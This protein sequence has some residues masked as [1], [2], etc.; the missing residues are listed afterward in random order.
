MSSWPPGLILIIG[1]LLLPVLRGRARQAVALALPLLSAW[2]L[3]MLPA[4]ARVEATIF[5]YELLVVRADKMA[6]VWGVIF[7]IAAFVSILYAIHVK[8]VGQHVAGLVYAGSAIGAVYAGDL[9]TLFVYWELTAI[10]SVFLVWASRT[11]RSYRSGMRYLVIQVGSGVILLS[12]ILMRV[13]AGQDLAFA[14]LGLQDVATGL[15]FVA[16]GI[17]AAFPLLHTWLKDAYPEATPTGTVF[18]SAF[19]TKL[20]IYALARCFPGTHVLIWIGAAMAIFPLLYAVIENDL[21]RV[22]SYCLINQLGFMIIGVGIGTEMSLNG[23]AAH[24]F[25]H[26]LYKSLLFMSIGAVLHRTGTARASELGGLHKWMPLTMLFCFIGAASISAPLFCGFI[27]KSMIISASAEEHLNS[28]WAI[29]WFA[30][31]GV[32]LVAGLKVPFTTF[33][34]YDPGWKVKEAPPNM[35]AAMGITAVFCVGVGSFPG[36]LYERLP[37]PVDYHPYSA[38]HVIQQ[39]QLLIAATLAFTWLTRRHLYPAELRATNLDADWVYRRGL[40]DVALGVGARAVSTWDA[41]LDW[42]FT[43]LVAV[44]AGV[45]RLCGSKGLFA[46]TWS[47]GAIAFSTALVFGGYLFFYFL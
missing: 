22:L 16:F 2:Q 24:A 6:H 12:G 33:F 31:A 9:I 21:R 5:D 8:D 20:A 36:L 46:R 15:I 34:G 32:F 43:R 11:E 1:S 26:I 29:L 37:Y 3:S 18:L 25:A 27:S 47:T 23:T 13:A 4:G 30:S 10:A 38:Y 14:D 28:I 45:M 17:K 39:L 40:R 41:L 44:F 35:L 7:H 42:L 19:T